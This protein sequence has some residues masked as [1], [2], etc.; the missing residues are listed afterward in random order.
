LGDWDRHDDQWRWVEYDLPDDEK[1]YKPIPRD[2]DVVFFA[3]EGV[4]K[5][6]AASKWAQPSLKGFHD[7]ISYTPS[8]GFYRIRWFDRYF[9]T[10]PSEADW[11]KQANELKAALTDEVIEKAFETWPDEIYDLHGDEIIRKLKNRRELLD[12]YAADYY[13]F[14]SKDVTILGSDKR[15]WFKVEQLNDEETKVTVIKISKKNNRDKVLYERTF[16]TDETKEIRLFGF[17]GEDE[18]E[19]T[20]DVSK[21]II[22]RIIGGED[23]DMIV[24]R[25]AV[26][27]LKKNTVVYDTKSSTILHTSK[28]TKDKTSDKDPNINR[29]NME[30][31]DFD[32]L[33]PLVAANYNPDDGIFIGGGFMLK[34]DGFR[35]EPYASKQSFT[36]VYAFA[37]SSFGLFYDADFKKAIGKADLLLK[38]EVRSPNFVNNFF[39]LGNNTEYNSELGLN[40]YRTRYQSYLLNPSLAFNLSPNIKLIFGTRFL[41]VEIEEEEN[42]GRFISDFPNNGLES[43]GLFEHKRYLGASLG[44]HIDNTDSEV[45]ARRVVTFN[46]ELRYNNGINEFAD[47]SGKFLTNVTFRWTPGIAQRTTFATRVGYEKSLGDYEFFQASQLDG[48]NTLR[49]YRRYRFAGES[50]FYQQLDVRVELFHWQN[51]LLPSTVG[52]IFFNDIGRVW[53]ENDESDKLHHGYGGGVYVTPLS[54]FAIN[55]L[56]ANSTE[57]LM[58]LVKLGFYF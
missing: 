7:E 22:V 55:L 41:D 11:V 20:G 6:I 17:D 58:P 14:L 16:K 47:N 23:E 33:M 38:A 43:E 44:L 26:S 45:Q 15:E 24:D 25:S 10:E 56:L 19:I 40:Y 52:L 30:E 27:G 1:L 39:G 21:G 32:V 31:Y 57:G 35:K 36:G 5:K 42:E 54:R 8:Y 34:K 29:Y 50:S 53:H 2:R 12:V 9:M 37:T 4:F 49:G 46:T 51:Y 48:F 28:E 18:F 3:G 13:K